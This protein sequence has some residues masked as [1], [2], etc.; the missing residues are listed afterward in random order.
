MAADRLFRLCRLVRE[1]P[2]RKLRQ[3]LWVPDPDAVP[4]RVLK[5]R[6]DDGVWCDGWVVRYA[7]PS[8]LPADQVP[9]GN[10]LTRVSP[11]AGARER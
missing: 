3:V 6:D 9:A 10:D 5:V 7:G 4:G 2:G 1:T 11:R 8:R